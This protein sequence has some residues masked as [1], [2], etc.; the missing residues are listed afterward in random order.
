V[1]TDRDDVD[2]AYV[3]SLTLEMLVAARLRSMKA[4]SWRR[5]GIISF[6]HVFS[7]ICPPYSLSKEHAWAILLTLERKGWLE[8][9][10]YHGVRLCGNNT[11]EAAKPAL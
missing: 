3:G 9:I 5:P 1:N 10:P 2:T 8:L 6:P 7:V 4:G 11:T